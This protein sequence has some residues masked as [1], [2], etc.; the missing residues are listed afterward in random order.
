MK[1]KAIIRATITVILLAVAIAL[2][3]I[4]F[5]SADGSDSIT[6]NRTPEIITIEIN[7]TPSPEP[8]KPTAEPSLEPTL[9]FS[10]APD[11]LTDN[12]ENN[13]NPSKKDDSSSTVFTLIIDGK[14]VDIAYGVAES[15]LENTPGWLENSASPG[16]EGVCVV[17]GHRNRNHL[18]ALKGIK[19]GDTITVKTT[20]GSYSYYVET[21]RIMDGDE[22]LTIPAMDGKYLMLS[23]CYPFFYSG[24]APQKLMVFAT[25]SH[26]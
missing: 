6:P 13:G 8:L 26:Y 20:G 9:G 3:V 4:A 10:S 2:G 25:E 15:T 5:H 17:Y 23:T 16:E 12:F 18:R 22:E 7:P 14:E 19:L 24:R 11:T 1:N 21:I